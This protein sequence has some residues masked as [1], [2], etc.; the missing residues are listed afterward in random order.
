MTNAFLSKNKTQL[1]VKYMVYHSKI[2]VKAR[3]YTS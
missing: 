1:W 3:K 2:V